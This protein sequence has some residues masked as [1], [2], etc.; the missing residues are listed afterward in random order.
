M[1]TG[2]R[3]KPVDMIVFNKINPAQCLLLWVLYRT[4]ADHVVYSQNMFYLTHRRSQ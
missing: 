2:Y 4:L 1:L 3:G